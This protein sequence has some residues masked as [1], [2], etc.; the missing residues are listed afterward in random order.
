MADYDVVIVGSGVAGAL[1]AAG[2]AGDGRKILVLEAA[3]NGLGVFQREQFRR[4]WDPATRKTWNTPYLSTTGIK[5]YPSP[6]S[7]DVS[8]YFDQPNVDQ[9]NDTTKSL[10]TFK[11]TYQ[12]LVGGSTWAWRGN[13]PRM[14]P[15]DFRV[16]SAYFPTGAFPDGAHVADWPISY[17]D[18]KP[19][20]LKAE[21]ELGV[22]GN[23]EEWETHTP[24]DGAKFP[25]PGQP[26]SY[27]DRELI[28]RFEKSGL[29]TVTLHGEQLP[30]QILTMAQA[31]NTQPY[32]GRPAC[33]GNHNCIPLCPTNAKYDASVHL[34]RARQSGVEIRTGCVVTKLE[35][36]AGGAISRVL[37][38]QWSSDSPQT[39]RAVTGDILILAANPIETPKILL[40]SGLYA[41]T[42]P[43]VGKYLMD[44]IQ[45]ECL[46]IAHD[47]IYPFRGPQTI[48]GIDSLRDGKYRAK[49]AS[50]RITLGNDGWGRHGNPTSVLEEALNPFELSK[51]SIG[52]KLRQEVVD[53]VTR[54]VRLSVS[55]EQLPHPEN[56][57]TLSDKTDDL[58]IRRPRIRFVVH[59][60]TQQALKE[61]FRVCKEIFRAMDAHVEEEEFNVKDWVTAA[62]PMGTCRMGTDKTNSVVD[63]FGR[64][65]N[66]PN[67]YI[68]GATVFPTGSATNPVLTLSA[69]ALM[70][71]DEIKK[72][73]S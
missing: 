44:H 40:N 68:V 7:D 61:G 62:H 9:T 67:L 14:M 21:Y 42:D 30:L 63:K 10:T 20:Y 2:L 24:R 73:K 49:F 32:D 26:K 29:K 27:S 12:R 39:E 19:W 41:E 66:H 72:R 69:L 70:T 53:K 3:E 6:V 18:L 55:T 25:M 15:N 1:C 28:S 8:T 37:Y 58:G 57:I 5:F 31:R 52:R 4:V 36:A 11:A 51:F 23:A 17:D 43:Y 64:C 46:G 33:E 48:S 50:F 16:K 54:L 59:D 34:K 65:H 45:G 60:Y 47:P 22:S 56:K 13:T 35:A 71:V 38:K